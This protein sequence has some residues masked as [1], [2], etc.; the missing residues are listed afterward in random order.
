[1][2]NWCDNQIIIRGDKKKMKPIVEIFKEFQK[3][4][5]EKLL[6]MK[7]LLG[8]ADRPKD[9]DEGGWWDYNIN[10]YGTKWDFSVENFFYLYVEDEEISFGNQT[11]WS[12]P[13]NFLMHL[14]KKYDVQAEITF[15]EPGNNFAGETKF[16]EKGIV[17]QVA[18]EYMEGLYHTD[19]ELFWNEL[20]NYF[21]D[22]RDEEINAKK[23][24]EDY[25]KYV[26]TKD[27]KEIK[28]LYTEY[29]EIHI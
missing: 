3:E 12:P 13:E 16:N 2:P 25:K 20:E 10:K 9:Y 17:K 15:S 8:I 22:S 14:C 18:Y 5:G 6:V 19:D 23:F 29:M 27:L 7:S 11:A 4:S 21:V 26:T 1:M 28:D 24:V